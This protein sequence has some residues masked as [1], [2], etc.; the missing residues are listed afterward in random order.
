MSAGQVKRSQAARAAKLAR[1]QCAAVIP[2]AGQHSTTRPAMK[3]CT[4]RA[5]VGWG[6]LCGL[7]GRAALAEKLEHENEQPDDWRNEP[8]DD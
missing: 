5:K 6:G 4:Y 8:D 3:R 1:P 7:H 2:D